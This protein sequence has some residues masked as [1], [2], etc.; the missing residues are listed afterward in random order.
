MSNIAAEINEI[1]NK[2]FQ[3]DNSNRFASLATVG[4]PVMKS[5]DSNLP[6]Q[7]LVFRNA[8]SHVKKLL[9]DNPESILLNTFIAKLYGIKKEVFSF[10]SDKDLQKIMIYTDKVIEQSKKYIKSER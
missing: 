4:L 10:G 1:S 6:N 7:L 3:I 2:I 9:I 5:I 8:M